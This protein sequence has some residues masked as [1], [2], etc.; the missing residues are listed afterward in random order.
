[1]IKSSSS[2]DRRCAVG[3]GGRR[4]AVGG[5]GRTGVLNEKTVNYRNMYMF[6]YQSGLI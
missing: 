1:M 4:C 5:G 2:I 3:G 6:V